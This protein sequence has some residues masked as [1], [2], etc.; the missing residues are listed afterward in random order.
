MRF[1]RLSKGKKAIVDDEDFEI[2]NQ[3]KWY[4]QKAPSNKYYARN[5]RLGLLHRFILN[6]DTVFEVDHING[7]SLD[8]RRNN[9]RKSTHHENMMN[10]KVH[11]SSK[12][13]IKGVWYREKKRR[14]EAQIRFNNKQIHLGLFRELEEA[15]KAR[16]MAELQYFRQFARR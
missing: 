13:G 4:A 8:N 10:R 12:S 16:R 11:K 7:N 14:W 9:L 6:I 3:Y 5:S 2:L 1:I 15:V